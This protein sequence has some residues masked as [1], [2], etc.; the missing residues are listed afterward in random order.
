MGGDDNGDDEEEDDK[1]EEEDVVAA[2]GEDDM[3][4]D[5]RARQKYGV[6]MMRH[7]VGAH[8]VSGRGLHSFTSPLNLRTLGTHRSR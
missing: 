2:A 1:E 7:Q 5:T 8:A 4:K 6:Y 3:G